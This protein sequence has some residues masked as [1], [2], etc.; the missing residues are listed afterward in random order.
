MAILDLLALLI[1]LTALFSW[2]NHRFLKLPTTIGVM[3]MGM[4]MSLLLIALDWLD[5]A[6]AERL[7]QALAT[8]DFN[9][10][11]MQGMLSF[12]L[13][14]GALHVKL[15]DLA[16]V[17]WLVGTMA[18]VGVV[19]S[20][21]VV[22]VLT[23]LV[24]GWIGIDIPWLIAFLFG[25]LISPTDPIAVLAILRKVGV[26]KRLEVKVTGESLFND[27]VGVVVFLLLLGVLTGRAELSASN[28]ALLFAT[29]AIGGAIF[30]FALGW[31]ANYML[32]R[33]DNYQVEVLLTLAVAMGGYAGAA[34]LHLS[35]PIAIVVAGLL[36]GNQ[37]RYQSMSETT[38][39]HVDTFWELIDEILNALLF[40][41]IG[42]ELLLVTAD[43]NYLLAGLLAIPIVLLGRIASVVPPV[44]L[45]GLRQQFPPKTVRLMVWGGLRGG[46]SVALA[47]SLPPGP[48]RDLLITVTYCVVV[49]SILVQGLTV[50]HVV[51]DK[52]DVV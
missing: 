36:I 47:L 22:G 45:F 24:F 50:G 10:V 49:F 29:E 8:V 46:I 13:F 44:K 31:V 16:H 25:A 2:F 51:A 28:A 1:S 15:S 23:K 5:V 11:L 42:V 32:A 4:T 52:R 27:G 33:V 3:V 7:E 21:I 37:G 18:T 9:T 17:R 35:G 6:I 41:L 14:A 19:I 40:V 48:E 20:T 34:A 12:L 39:E 26:D 38:R 30:G 43:V